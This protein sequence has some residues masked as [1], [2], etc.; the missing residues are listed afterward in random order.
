MVVTIDCGS[1]SYAIS[2]DASS[3]T[4][5]L[6]HNKYDTESAEDWSEYGDYEVW[7]IARRMLE[8]L[9]QEDY[10]KMPQQGREEFPGYPRIPAEDDEP[11]GSGAETKSVK[12]HGPLAKENEQEL[13]F[14]KPLANLLLG[15]RAYFVHSSSVYCYDEN[16]L[17][18]HIG[19]GK[20]YHQ[21]AAILPNP[22]GCQ[23]PFDIGGMTYRFDEHNVLCYMMGGR[24]LPKNIY[25]S[26]YVTASD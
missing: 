9:M 1:V 4:N 16:R 8:N 2:K 20:C 25:H 23:V 3:S 21:V 7:V 6:G 10:K 11:K 12:L 24:W 13:I 26:P 15:K 5:N 22:P 19:E 17:I 14:E 18:F